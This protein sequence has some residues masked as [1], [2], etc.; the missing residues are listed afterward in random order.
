[1]TRL[2]GD[3]HDPPGG[4]TI[5]TAAAVVRRLRQ[6]R[7]ARGTPPAWQCALEAIQEM[8]EKAAGLSAVVERIDD[9]RGWTPYAD[10]IL[11]G[12]VLEAVGMVRATCSQAVRT[13]AGAA[14]LALEIASDGRRPEI[15]VLTWV[16]AHDADLGTG[17][18][19]RIASVLAR[20]DL[21]HVRAALAWIDACRQAD[22]YLTALVEQPEHRECFDPDLGHSCEQAEALGARAEEL[23]YAMAAYA[24]AL[25]HALTEIPLP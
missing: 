14:Q 5:L 19:E 20:Q 4:P 21:P 25:C 12:G 9:V 6:T 15:E 13:L 11:N 10:P 3:D 1:M 2:P 24:Y 17:W 8:A 22:A 23:P 7:F 18:P 16:Q